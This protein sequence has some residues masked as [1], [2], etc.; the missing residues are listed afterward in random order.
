MFLEHILNPILERRVHGVKKAMAVAI[1][2]KLSFDGVGEIGGGAVHRR[3]ESG[4]RLGIGL[5]GLD[6]PVPGRK[7]I[8]LGGIKDGSADDQNGNQQDQNPKPAL[9]RRR[10]IRHPRPG[11]LKRAPISFRLLLLAK[12]RHF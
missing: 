1:F 9:R 5:P 11:L 8:A 10:I 3:V 6:R 7:R 4:L 2:V 12:S